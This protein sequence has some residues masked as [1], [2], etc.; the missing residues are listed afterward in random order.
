MRH[1]RSPDWKHRWLNASDPY[2]AFQIWLD[3]RWPHPL[4]ETLDVALT[5]Y[6][7]EVEPL[8]QHV[9]PRARMPDDPF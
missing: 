7:R 3:A 1:T 9:M 5:C 8:Q 4:A 2:E 6:G